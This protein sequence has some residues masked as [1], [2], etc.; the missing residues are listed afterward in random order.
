M[1]NV[2]IA[3]GD[4]PLAGELI[5]V[6]VNHPDVVIRGISCPALDGHYLTS[7]HHG[8][9]G[10][11]ALKFSAALDLS[12]LDVLFVANPAGHYGQDIPS[13]A[14][15]PELSVVDLYADF[16][17]AREIDPLVVYGV[18]EISRKALVRGAKRAVIPSAQEVL[19]AIALYPLAQKSML[20]DNLMVEITTE[21]PDTV[22]PAT[23][24]LETVLQP[25]NKEKPLSLSYKAHKGDI[26][27][28]IV[29]SA[30]ISTPMPIDNIHELYDEIYDDHNMTF[31]VN[32]E[33]DEKEVIGTDKC[34]VSITKTETGN[35][36]IKAYADAILR[37]GAGD[38]VHVMN[39]LMGLY[40]KTGLSLKANMF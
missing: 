14:E 3:G 36:R 40:E 7:I 22:K 16:A 29:F 11:Q 28:G 1:I 34:I 4:D 20:P 15:A 2:G 5:R 25:A 12:S 24:F 17:E 6:L 9:I 37:G 19:T 18:P 30:E 39:L 38:A 35:V 8:L 23:T 32:D 26:H 10:E 13:P 31:I 33:I 27:R 21:Y